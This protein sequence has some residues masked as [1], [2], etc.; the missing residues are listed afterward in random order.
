MNLREKGSQTIIRGKVQFEAVE[1]RWVTL[2]CKNPD[3]RMVPTHIQFEWTIRWTPAKTRA[4]CQ[5]LSCFSQPSIGSTYS[6]SN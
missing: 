5:T 4:L 6:P 1:Q 2:F 3:V